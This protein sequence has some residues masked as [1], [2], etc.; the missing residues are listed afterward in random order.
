MGTS[1]SGNEMFLYLEETFLHLEIFLSFADMLKEANFQEIPS[2][3][4]TSIISHTDKLKEHFEKYFVKNCDHLVWVND[5][6]RKIP[7]EIN[8]SEKEQLIDLQSELIYIKSF[9]NLSLSEF[10]ISIKTDFLN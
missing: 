1:I 7:S 10:C 8:I 4:N 2:L 9:K 6:F 5:S 3:V